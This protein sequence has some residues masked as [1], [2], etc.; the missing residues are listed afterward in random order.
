MD[1]AAPSSSDVDA[2]FAAVYLEL[3]ELVSSSLRHRVDAADVDD[4][5]AEVFVLLLRKLREG[6]RPDSVRAW[7]LGAGR[8]VAANHRRGQRRHRERIAQL[9]S[10]EVTSRDR[11]LMLT[12]CR[13]LEELPSRDRQTFWLA[14]V[15]GRSGHELA[16][17][18]GCRRSTAYARAA[19]VRRRLRRQLEPEREQRGL[20][21]TL[22]ALWL[23]L[24]QRRRLLLTTTVFLAALSFPRR[25]A[26]ED[27]PAIE[28][29]KGEGPRSAAAPVRMRRQ[30]LAQTVRDPSTAPAPREAHLEPPRE[31]PVPR[32]V[33]TVE[34]V[35]VLP[36][37]AAP[38][39]A[40]PVPPPAP[41]AGPTGVLVDPEGHPVAHAR[42]LC[43]RVTRTG[44]R[45]RCRARE[46]V[47]TDVRGT[48]TW[49]GLAPGRYDFVAIEPG[50]HTTGHPPLSVRIGPDGHPL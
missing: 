31:R 15:E 13:A 6:F 32:A 47:W 49:A 50:A 46:A 42:V 4:V 3:R 34:P 29:A 38:V 12:L 10:L 40:P 2:A 37:P 8:R 44:L 18:L 36:V 39:V 20:A 43:R 26:S 17:A 27:L 22:G 9:P 45:R 16:E 30:I 41:E 28:P 11:E 14:D 21:A 35:I 24:T 25:G 5:T 7:L 19:G 23:G 33:T 1:G 48:F